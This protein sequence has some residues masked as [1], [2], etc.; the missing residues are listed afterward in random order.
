MEKASANYA[1]AKE[2]RAS[3]SIVLYQDTTIA[4]Y[5]G[6]A[7]ALYRDAASQ[8]CGKT[9]GDGFRW[10]PPASAGGAGL[11]SSGEGA[12]LKW[13]LAP[14]LPIPGAKA[15]DQSRTL[16]GSAQALPL[17]EV[18]SMGHVPIFRSRFSRVGNNRFVSGHGF[19]P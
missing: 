11:Q 17:Q 14:G 10:D 19:S 1:I 9:L 8:S 3:S 12:V 18:H 2:T 7:T 4:L 13:A 15:R 5:R 16:P 6:T